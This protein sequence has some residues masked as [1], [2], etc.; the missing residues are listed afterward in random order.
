MKSFLVGK[1]ISMHGLRDADLSD[2]APYFSWLDNLEL[3][4]YAERSRFAVNPETFRAYVKKAWTNSDLVLLGIYDNDSGKHIGNISIKQ[5]DWQSRKGW[6]GYLMGDPAFRN[7]GLTTE[8][9]LMFMYYCF[10]KLNL[11][12]IYTHINENNQPSIRVIE[13]A[14]FVKEGVLREHIINGITPANSFAYGSLAH[15]WLP[16]HAEKARGLYEQVWF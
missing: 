12:R 6:I 3:D 5:I 13:K 15:E 2:T 16:T 8:A 1:H 4:Q 14:G 9:V 11:R 7:R 10:N